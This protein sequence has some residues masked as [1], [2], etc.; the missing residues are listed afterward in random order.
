MR[1][2]WLSSER[3][4]T[5]T[6]SSNSSPSATQSAIFAFSEEESKIERIF[7]RFLDPRAPEKLRFSRQ[8]L[9]YARFSRSRTEPVP[10]SGHH[11][12][13]GFF[14]YISRFASGLSEGSTDFVFDILLSVL[15]MSCAGLGK[16][17]RSKVSVWSQ[18]VSC[19]IRCLSK[20]RTAEQITALGPQNWK[21]LAPTPLHLPDGV[22]T[23]RI[24]PT[25]STAVQYQDAQQSG[26][27]ST[28]RLL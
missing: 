23:I 20:S 2:R 21:P 14:A 12:L 13:K 4:S 24:H 27:W 11:L 28:R 7:A 22:G 15:S 25:Q 26:L 10:L 3:S 16:P 9:I 17:I 6:G 5:G 18:Y 19:P 1:A 8:Q